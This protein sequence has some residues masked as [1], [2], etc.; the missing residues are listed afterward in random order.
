MAWANVQAFAFLDNYTRW[1]E[2]DAASTAPGPL[3]RLGQFFFPTLSAET[4][5][6]CTPLNSWFN[7]SVIEPC[8]NR[9]DL[10]FE[11]S[12]CGWTSWA[13]TLA[14]WPWV[15]WVCDACNQGVVGCIANCVLYGDCP[16][17]GGGTG[18]G[19]DGGNWQYPCRGGSE[20]CDLDSDC[21]ESYCS[22]GF[23]LGG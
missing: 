23:C 5:D 10:C 9:H 22:E 2:S 1:K 20:F 18:G 19:G 4:P 7:G 16:P 3:A 21:C 14:S 8:C 13:V 6:G 11:W 17:S 15:M 12:G